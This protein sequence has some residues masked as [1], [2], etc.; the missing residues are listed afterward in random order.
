[1][2]GELKVSEMI[3]TVFSLSQECHYKAWTVPFSLGLK[4]FKD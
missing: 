3:S 2:L 1:M 4:L